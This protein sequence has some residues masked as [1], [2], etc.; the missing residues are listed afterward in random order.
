MKSLR[1]I[2]VFL[3]LAAL[4]ARAQDD[5]YQWKEASSGSYTYRYV[6][7]DPFQ[8]RVYT[9]ANG[10]TV[11]LSPNHKEPRVAVRIAVRAGS[12]TDPRNHTGLAHY[13]EHLPRVWRYLEA[14]LA[15]PGLGPLRRWFD[16]S[17]PP[18]LRGLPA[19]LAA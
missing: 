5:R 16:R 10:L 19:A 17:L 2:L 6:T 3:F 4:A 11:I 15:H 18:A 9:L 1:L 12:N 7:N 8:A 14:A 13:L